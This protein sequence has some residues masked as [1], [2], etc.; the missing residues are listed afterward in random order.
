MTIQSGKTAAVRTKHKRETCPNPNPAKVEAFRKRKAEQDDSGDTRRRQDLPPPSAR[1]HG[2]TERGYI[3]YSRGFTD[4]LANAESEYELSLLA[5]VTED[6]TPGDVR[7]LSALYEALQ[8]TPSEYSPSAPALQPYDGLRESG[9]V[10]QGS[11]GAN[12]QVN[13]Q[14]VSDLFYKPTIFHGNQR[15]KSQYDNTFIA[16]VTKETESEKFQ[17][18]SKLFETLHMETDSTRRSKKRPERVFLKASNGADWRQSSKVNSDIH[19][20]S[21]LLDC[22]RPS[23]I[24]GVEDFK[25]IK[26]QYPVMIQDS[27]EYKESN[28]NYQFGGGSKTF[29][30]GRVR[31]PIYVVDSSHIPH[32]STSMCGSRSSTSQGCHS[33]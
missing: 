1:N 17:P 14:P 2:G 19:K 33:C 24:V 5:E 7:P 25:I 12:A 20:L 28:K 31:L 11:V 21:M 26:E 4:Q 18:L 8:S 30:M 3:A 23:T 15:A 10:L 29:S 16:K 6:N 32:H 27:F 22:G 13:N 9:L